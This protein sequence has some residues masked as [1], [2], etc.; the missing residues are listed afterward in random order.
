LTFLNINAILDSLVWAVSQYWRIELM[1]KA[2]TLAE[3]L[4]TLGVIGVIA[5]M[6]LPA[7]IANS[8]K[9]ETSVKLKK[10]YSTMEQAIRLS[11]ID[12]GD[13]SGWDVPDTQN[14]K[15]QIYD[16]WSK[17]IMPYL[18]GAKLC[19]MNEVTGVC[20]VPS[21]HNNSMTIII[22]L[23]DGS[24]IEAYI[25]G[26]NSISSATHIV[27][28]TDNKSSVVGKNAFYFRYNNG[29]GQ[30][31]DCERYGSPPIPSLSMNPTREELLN[32]CSVSPPQCTCLLMHDGWEFKDDYPLKF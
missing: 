2:F 27:L 13:M 29:S 1:K 7:L 30:F 10:F 5:T 22:L 31:V 23:R 25:G 12:N 19:G 9:K 6:T 15:Q 4:I 11:Q 8:R 3:V 14:N 16:W 17:Y 26:A 24:K 21:G 28:H 18:S 32:G 20:S